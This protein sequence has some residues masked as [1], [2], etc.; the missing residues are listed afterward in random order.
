MDLLAVSHECVTRK[1]IVMLPACQLADPADR[2]VYRAQPGAIALAPNHAFMESGTDLA[3]TLD[4]GAVCV[5]QQLRV[6]ERTS[7][8]LVDAYRHHHPGLPRSLSD[9]LRGG[10]GYRYG[11]IEQPEMLLAGPDLERGLHEGK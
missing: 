1:G 10:R 4:Q 8:A 6:V 3:A 2:A 9:G 11:L 7:V 5:E